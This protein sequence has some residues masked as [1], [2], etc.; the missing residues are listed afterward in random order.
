[1]EDRTATQILA[2]VK[3]LV[4][5]VDAM[6][7]ELQTQARRAAALE[8]AVKALRSEVEALSRKR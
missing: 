2:E 1:M 8:T 4:T 6:H 7:R 5:T 3:K